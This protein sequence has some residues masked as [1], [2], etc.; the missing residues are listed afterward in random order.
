MKGHQGGQAPG[1]ADT[2][3]HRGTSAS[4]VQARGTRRVGLECKSPLDGTFY[5]LQMPASFKNHNQLLHVTQPT[6]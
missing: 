3:G 1:S 4:L 2:D 6:I 5:F